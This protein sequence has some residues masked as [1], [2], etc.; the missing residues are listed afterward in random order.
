MALVEVLLRRGDVFDDRVA[1]DDVEAAVGDRQAR[2]VPLNERHAAD[3]LPRASR[4]PE[5]WKR[6]SRSRPTAKS[7]SSA[8]ERAVPP[9]PHPASST[10]PCSVTPARS[11][12]WIALALRRYSN[13]A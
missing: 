9:P 11:R 2:A 8:R 3:L 7:A 6:A 13:T 10:C 12:P 1:E 5:S 4:V